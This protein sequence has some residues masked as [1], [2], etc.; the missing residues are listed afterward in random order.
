MNHG[1]QSY[2]VNH[3]YCQI[4]DRLVNRPDFVS[5]PRGMKT[6]E[7]LFVTCVLINPLSRCIT[8]PSRNTNFGFA[9]GEFLWYLGG[10]NDL[11]HIAYYNKRMTHYSDDGKTLNS[12]YGYRI[13]GNDGTV[14]NQW[15][16]AYRKLVIDK[17]TR[18]AIIHIN[19]P[20]DQDIQ[21]KDV[22]CTLSF[23]F[24]IREHA[25]YMKVVMRS[26]DVIYG[27]T[28][29]LFSFT[30]FQEMM[31]HR[32]KKIYPGLKLGSYIHMADSLHLYEEHFTMAKNIVRNFE[33]GIQKTITHEPFDE[34]ELNFLA[35]ND[36][37]L[38]RKGT[39]EKID[40]GRYKNN[41]V[42]W[43]VEELNKHAEKRRNEKVNKNDL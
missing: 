31:W 12:A 30:L 29:D 32:L 43:M 21:T 22:P 34:N 7:L 25:L 2:T 14:P 36:E 5:S 39:I 11:D 16:N 17:D 41:T 42:R 9:V 13:F 8:I 4:A 23:S 24:L 33:S 28:Y 1:F 37:I 10:Y 15:E 38:L 19:L 20:K 3:L 26:N 6:N 27:L 18:Q 40:L 35:Q